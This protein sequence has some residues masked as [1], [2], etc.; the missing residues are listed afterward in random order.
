MYVAIDVGGTN[1]RV[2]S[3][4]FLTQP[5]TEKIIEF[6][7]SNNYQADFENIVKTAKKLGGVKIEGAGVGVPGIL[8]KAK[9]KIYLTTNLSH[10]QGKPFKQHLLQILNCPVVSENDTAVAAL[11]EANYGYD[12]SKDFLFIVW[13]TGIGGAAINHI[14]GKICLFPFEPGKQIIDWDDEGHWCGK[15]GCLELFSGGAMIQARYKKPAEYLS[16][17]EWK[18]VVERFAH[19]LLNV[20]AIRPTNLIIFGGGIAV[21]QPKRVEQSRQILENHLKVFPIP[22]MKISK[23]GKD[24]GLYGAL[25][26]LNNNYWIQKAV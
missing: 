6:K 25:A 9:E 16:E 5:K 24:I 13:G 8:D 2:A 3:F 1:I 22:T 21:G 14:N 23:Y 11:G 18:E 15:R 4:K 20:I 26:L 7:T 10:W 17:M 19:G 12:K